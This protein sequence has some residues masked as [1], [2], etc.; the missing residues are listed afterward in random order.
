MRA[1]RK[2]LGECKT[3]A[4]LMLTVH[5]GGRSSW[6]WSL[7]RGRSRCRICRGRTRVAGCG[8]GTWCAGRVP[9]RS[10]PAGPAGCAPGTGHSPHRSCKETHT[11]CHTAATRGLARL[12]SPQDGSHCV[13]GLGSPEPLAVTSLSR[14]SRTLPDHK[15]SPRRL[16]S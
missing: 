9:T 7:V 10:W 14:A 2:A 15:H 6:T 12:V 3:R 11:A 8:P 5:W 4:E 16:L 13:T 1:A